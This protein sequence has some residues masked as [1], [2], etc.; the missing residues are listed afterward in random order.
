MKPPALASFIEVRNFSRHGCY[1]AIVV[2]T[3]SSVQSEKMGNFSGVAVQIPNPAV[4]LG[5]GMPP[6]PVLHSPG[7]SGAWITGK[8]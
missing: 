1:D 6:C 4:V 7:V 5:D 3:M 8:C 2:A